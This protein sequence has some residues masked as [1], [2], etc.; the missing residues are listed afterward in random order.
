MARR[1]HA[2]EPDRAEAMIRDRF[3][4]QHRI[5][6]HLPLASSRLHFEE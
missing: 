6:F 2:D 3:E 4:R 5:S 1:Y